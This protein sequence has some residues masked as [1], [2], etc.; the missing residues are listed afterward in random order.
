MLF[1]SFIFLTLF[2]PVSMD[3]VAVL[4]DVVRFGRARGVAS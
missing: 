1:N 2:L 4:A 3:C